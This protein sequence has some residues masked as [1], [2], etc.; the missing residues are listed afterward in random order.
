MM[1]TM[2]QRF[3]FFESE[4][5]AVR[6]TL[7]TYIGKEKRPYPRAAV[8]AG[9]RL[10]L[11]LCLPRRLGVSGG[12]LSLQ[13]DETGKDVLSLPLVYDGDEGQSM[14][15]SCT[16]TESDTKQ[17]LGL[18]FYRITLDTVY[19]P[20]L[21]TKT[22]S[23][24]RDEITVMRSLA[25]A[26]EKQRFQLTVSRFTH[27]APAWLYG[28]VIYHVFVDR[29]KRGAETPVRE[30]AILNT[31]WEKGVPQ[32]PPYP[33]APLANNMFFGGN[34]QGIEEKLDYFQSLGVTCLYLSPIF[35]AASNHK[36]DTGNYLKIDQM[37]GGEEA[38]C[39]L[40]E[41]AKEKG[42]RIVL[43]GVFNHTGDDSVYFNRKGRYD[44]LGAYQ[45][46]DSPY[47]G[48]YRFR[49]FPDKY[50]CWWDIPILPRL[51]PEEE[52]CRDF[53]IGREG[54]IAHYAKMGIGGFRLDVADEL[55]DSFIEGIKERLC[56]SVPDAVLYGE[57]WEDASNKIA[58][59]KRRAYYCGRELDGVMNYPL[60][61]GIVS[62]LREGKTD[63]LRYALC[64]VLPNAP[65]R[66][67]D[68]QMN[69]LGT[70]D[71]ER[72]LTVLAGKSAGSCT[73]DELA[74]LRMTETEY[75]LGVTRLR[76]AYTVLA[77]LP[78][79]PTVFY[80]DEVGMQG[81]RDPFNR[82]PFP[83]HRMDE[84]LLS[85]YRALGA[86]RKMHALYKTGEFALLRL[87]EN[88]LAFLR[89]DE[90]NAALTFVNASDRSLAFD[91]PFK[92]EALHG[93]Q[94]GNAEIPLQSAEVFFFERK[95]VEKLPSLGIGLSLPY[96]LE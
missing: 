82:L 81:Y 70:H 25:H 34:L 75:A 54:V 13:S 10:A 33:G 69:L 38:F 19:G 89:Y 92:A 67:A 2:Y 20:L 31:D 45:S 15:F 79:V 50:E 39:S 35:E 85:H 30:D 78:G 51:F 62:Y 94:K 16:L 14:R 37:F 28:S 1:G 57:V 40:L 63:A 22:D 47:Y 6:G 65:K 59:G 52:S 64:E 83:W 90:T 91:L 61:T 76:M 74:T 49:D 5:D 56:E 21:V 80:G 95:T 29:F 73:N 77:T 17:L 93:T 36:Y 11:L 43:D 87:D 42:I 41:K 26:G 4:L 58:Y 68:A 48:W 53:F 71:T 3:R 9:T 66:I 96:E 72:I 12:A 55:S 84:A 27:E 24:R 60:R 86:W 46:K 44:S 32:Y 23:V 88:A 7:R 18:Y 8:D